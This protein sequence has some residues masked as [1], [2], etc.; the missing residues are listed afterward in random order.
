MFVV[1]CLSPCLLTMAD[2][3]N[4]SKAH[5]IFAYGTLKR[6]F[7]NHT[8]MQSLIHQND[9]VFLGPF[10]TCISYPLVVGPHGI[11]FLINLP[12][13]GNRVTGELYSVSARGLF[14]VD[15]LEGTSLG[16]YERLPVKVIP[17]ESTNSDAGDVIQVE[18]EAYYSHRSFGEGL[19][20]RKGREGLS[21]YTVLCIC[22]EKLIDRRRK[23]MQLSRDQTGQRLFHYISSTI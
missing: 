18:A 1:C 12:G 14:L 4:Q 3:S 9:A 2:V 23:F 13:L 19:W 22:C 7:P 21:A 20:E 17:C 5:L 8:L 11:P 15:D 10:V 16:H 6:G